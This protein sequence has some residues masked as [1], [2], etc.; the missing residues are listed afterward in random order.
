[1]NSKF[2]RDGEKSLNGFI[3]RR[4]DKRV[5]MCHARC[6]Y[7]ASKTHPEVNFIPLG[8]EMCPLSRG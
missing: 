1:M 5:H 8:S 2:L 7:F 6:H 4:Q 3:I